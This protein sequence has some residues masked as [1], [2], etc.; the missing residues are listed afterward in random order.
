MKVLT[1]ERTAGRRRQRTRALRLE[2]AGVDGATPGQDLHL[3]PRRLHHR[4][5]AR[6]LQRRRRR[7]DRPRL[8]LQLA[9]DCTCPRASCPPPGTTPPLPSPARPCTPRPSKFEKV[10]FKDIKEGASPASARPSAADGWIAMVQHYFASAWLLPRRRAA[11]VPHRQG[12]PT[13]TTPWRW[14]CRWARWRP[15]RARRFEARL[16]AGPRRRTSSPRWPRAWSSSRTTARSPCWP[17]RCSG[18]STSCTG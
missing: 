3:P 13:T 6:A 2:S 10:D 15:A 9:R 16:F 5:R 7:G 17:S 8:Y 11:R 4:R 1:S 14:W 12:R 18:C